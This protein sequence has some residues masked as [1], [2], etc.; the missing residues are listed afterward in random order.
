MGKKIMRLK[1]GKEQ[2]LYGAAKSV[3]NWKEKVIQR[4]I[5]EKDK[6]TFQDP[7]DRAVVKVLLRKKGKFRKGDEIRYLRKLFGNFAVF[8]AMMKFLSME[9]MSRLFER[10]RYQRKKQGEVIFYQGDTAYK[11]YV[12]IEGEVAMLE[13][14]DGVNGD[15]GRQEV[16]MADPHQG[17]LCHEDA[18]KGNKLVLS[19]TH[20]STAKQAHDQRVYLRQRM[21][22]HQVENPGDPDFDIFGR[23]VEINRYHAGETF[24]EVALTN[25][26]LR[27]SSARALRETHLATLT[28][29]D[30]N[31][32]ILKYHEY[33][34][35]KK[36]RWLQSFS[37]LAKADKTIVYEIFKKM[38]KV[39]Y[40]M[41]SHIYEEGTKP[42]YL[43]FIYAGQIKVYPPN[44]PLSLPS[45]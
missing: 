6:V 7:D 37:C 20:S 23:S 34:Y 9:L 10:V 4:G 3:L 5:Y 21:N 40:I 42:K 22:Q 30:Y 31:E 41:N 12:I 29:E 43:Y 38:K 33:L 18:P 26:S 19:H 35:N 44:P 8:Q 1:R 25:L 32:I 17:H 27:R 11:F 2:G 39:D 13:E 15:E 24:G 14:Q 36:I 28:C 16:R 45:L